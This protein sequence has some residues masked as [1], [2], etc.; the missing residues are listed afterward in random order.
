MP[1]SRAIR[2]RCVCGQNVKIVVRGLTEKAATGPIDDKARDVLHCE[3]CKRTMAES[4]REIREKGRV[5]VGE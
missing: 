4:D 5:K 2:Y 3:K 1:F